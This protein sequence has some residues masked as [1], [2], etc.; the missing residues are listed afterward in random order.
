MCV[1]VYIYKTDDMMQCSSG[2]CDIAVITK[3][4]VNKERFLHHPW[5]TGH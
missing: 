1:C 4:V 5:G 3:T 2:S